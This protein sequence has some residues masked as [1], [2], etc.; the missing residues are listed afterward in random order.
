MVGNSFMENG[1]NWS[2]CLNKKNIRNWGIIGDEV[3][4]IC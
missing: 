4:G 2:K 3:L 1:G